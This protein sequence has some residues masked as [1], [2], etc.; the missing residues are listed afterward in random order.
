MGRYDAD[1]GAMLVNKGNNKFSVENINGLAIKGEVRHVRKIMI[2]GK[3]AYILARN[4][5][6][7]VVIDFKKADK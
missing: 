7:G 6:T 3:E 1:F 2:N 4:N 5:D